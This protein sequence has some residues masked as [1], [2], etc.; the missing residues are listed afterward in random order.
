MQNFGGEIREIQK[1]L[2]R[3]RH[4]WEDNNIKMDVS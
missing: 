1:Q 2:G 3:S 4:R